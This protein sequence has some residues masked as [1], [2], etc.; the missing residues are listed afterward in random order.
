[1]EKNKKKSSGVNHKT[2]PKKV[3]IIYSDVKRK[4]FPT[5]AQYLTE[6]D[7]Y[8][9]P[10]VILASIFKKWELKLFFSLPTKP[11]RKK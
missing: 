8:H 11:F 6:K 2:L 10:L 3:L 9:D 5:E 4:Y 1:M 7:A